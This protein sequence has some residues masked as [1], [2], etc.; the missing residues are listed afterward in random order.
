MTHS[1]KYSKRYH[2]VPTYVP[3]MQCSIDNYNMKY[4]YSTKSCRCFHLEEA[5]SSSDTDDNRHSDSF[6]THR[7]VCDCSDTTAD[8]AVL[9][10]AAA[11]AIATVDNM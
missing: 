6:P 7:H 2:N 10:C 4:K 11:K 8:T 5:D 1:Q 9:R 3:A